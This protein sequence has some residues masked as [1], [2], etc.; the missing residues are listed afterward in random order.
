[1]AEVLP[2][3]VKLNGV[4]PEHLPA[5][6]K[7]K[8]D[9]YYAEKARRKDITQEGVAQEALDVLEEIDARDGSSSEVFTVFGYSLR[10]LKQA[11]AERERIQ[12]E[13]AVKP[14][15]D[16]SSEILSVAE[17]K[18]KYEIPEFKAEP[19]PE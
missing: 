12:R 15:K 19:I 2:E 1:M 13:L 14:S 7:T 3:K 4:K 5:S 8:Y 10:V 9:A 11:I 17:V 6:E 16:V 18:A